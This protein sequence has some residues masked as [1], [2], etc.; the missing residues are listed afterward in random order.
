MQL[1]SQTSTNFKMARCEHT[2]NR[3]EQMDM[4]QGIKFL[5]RLSVMLFWLKINFNFSFSLMKNTIL[6]LVFF[7][8]QC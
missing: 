3:N 5:T 1:A 6:V 2:T 7:F 4:E 8:F